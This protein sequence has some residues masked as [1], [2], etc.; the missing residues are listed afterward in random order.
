MLEEL[1]A[2]AGDELAPSRVQLWPEHFDLALELG[3]VE[4]GRAAYGF[5]PGDELHPEP[6]MYVA[7]WQA[8][9]PS[10]LWQASAFKGAELSHAELLGAA[11][12]RSCALEFFSARLAALTR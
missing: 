9:E 10:E 6:Y 4:G 2:G 11:D 7:P 12:Q 8:P 1:R 3:A 5:S